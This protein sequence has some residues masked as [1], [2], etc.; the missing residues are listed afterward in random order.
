MSHRCEH[1]KGFEKSDA[2][3]GDARPPA[4]WLNGTLSP[5]FSVM[6][7]AIDS[8]EPL[9]SISLPNSAPRMKIRKN[10][11][12]RSASVRMSANWQAAGSLG[13]EANELMIDRL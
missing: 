12:M 3:V 1:K 2:I 9:A 6:Y 4:Q 8:T 13:L 7:L 11:V 10:C 5:E